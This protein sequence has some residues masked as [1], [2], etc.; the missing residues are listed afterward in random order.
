MLRELLHRS[1]EYVNAVSTSDRPNH[2]Q[3]AYVALRRCLRRWAE[4][5]EELE[6]ET[7]TFMLSLASQ[8]INSGLRKLVRQIERQAKQQTN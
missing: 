7:A 8:R 1:R 2:E 5:N 3:E 6:H 4:D